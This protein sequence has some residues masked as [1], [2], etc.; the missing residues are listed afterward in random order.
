MR[1]GEALL[2]G[3]FRCGHCGRKLHVPSPGKITPAET[4]RSP[5]PTP[6][7]RVHF[8]HQ[9][10]ETEPPLDG[11]AGAAE[12]V[13]DDHDRLARPTEMERPIDKRILKLGRFL[14][15]LNLLRRRLTNVDDRQPLLMLSRDLLGRE[16]GPTR[17]E[18]PFHHLSPPSAMGS[19]SD[20]GSVAPTAVRRS[21]AAA[22]SASPKRSGNPVVPWRDPSQRPTSRSA[23]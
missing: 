10:L 12:I 6:H 21:I 2:A 4:S 8:R 1:R 11:A 13:V 19:G 18:I 9:P 5:E 22:A 14:I 16:A 17:R 3:L 7:G 23:L 15:A 20:A